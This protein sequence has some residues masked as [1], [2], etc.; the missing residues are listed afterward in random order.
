MTLPGSAPFTLGALSH[1]PFRRQESAGAAMTLTV[2]IIRVLA[3]PV[4]H[5]VFIRNGR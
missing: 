5:H 3:V 1:Q 4:A 2:W